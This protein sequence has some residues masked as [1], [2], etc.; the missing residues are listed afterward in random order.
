MFTLF[1]LY[2][3]VLSMENRKWATN[4]RSNIYFYLFN[5]DQNSS[6]WY[7]DTRLERLK[8]GA[9]VPRSDSSLLDAETKN[10]T[11]RSNR[12]SIILRTEE[13]VKRSPELSHQSVHN[14]TNIYK[15]K[16]SAQTSSFSIRGQW[17]LLLFHPDIIV[18]QRIAMPLQVYWP[19][20]VL[21]LRTARCWTF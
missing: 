2:V 20:F 16:K 4:I 11:S 5:C 18:N 6:E 12:L 13:R 21:F 7:H 9:M 17:G 15:S 10:Q 3:K 14:S 8:I 1:V 19:R